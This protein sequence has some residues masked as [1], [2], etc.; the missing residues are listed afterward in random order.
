MDP[1]VLTGLELAQ[2]H[3]AL[4]TNTSLAVPAHVA[5]E[6]ATPATAPLPAGD[7]AAALAQALREI[8]AV[9]LGAFDEAWPNLRRGR[10][11]QALDQVADGLRKLACALRGEGG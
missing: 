1:I 7:V 8:R 5:V 6:P 9:Y 3:D 10:A 11:L 2:I 4:A